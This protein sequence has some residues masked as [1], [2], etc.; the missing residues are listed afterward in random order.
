MKILNQFSLY[1]N[2]LIAK[3]KLTNEKRQEYID[4]SQQGNSL[5]VFPKF[6]RADKEIVTRSMIKDC[7]I[8]QLQFVHKALQ[9]DKDIAKQAIISNPNNI[10]Y[11]YRSLKDDENFLLDLA[12]DENAIIHLPA[13][14]SR[15]IKDESFILEYLKIKANHVLPSL[16]LCK[17]LTSNINFMREAV[18]HSPYVY[19]YVNK[20]NIQDKTLATIVFSNLNFHIYNPKLINLY[21]SFYA[22]KYEFNLLI[23]RNN[24]NIFKFLSNDLQENP[25][26]CK[27]V[28]N[29][30][31]LGQESIY[32]EEFKK[33]KNIIFEILSQKPNVYKDLHPEM[34]LE[35]R[36]AKAAL[37]LDAKNFAYLPDKLSKNTA[38]LKIIY[39]E[40]PNFLNHL[41][42]NPYHEYL[43]S[44]K[45][46]VLL[47]ISQLKNTPELF[48]KINKIHSNDLEIISKSL[49]ENPACYEY[50][51]N[52]QREQ[53]NYIIA[54]LSQKIFK[55]IRYIP[56]SIFKNT[57]NIDKLLYNMQQKD[58]FKPTE[59]EKDK[60]HL[61]RLAYKIF[62]NNNDYQNIFERLGYSN[63]IEL[64]NQS[65]FD[66]FSFFNEILK[67]KQA[68]DT[69]KCLIN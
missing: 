15:L 63:F 48:Q 66:I 33:N 7:P 45:K 47:S 22:D 68:L 51:S 17:E 37:I 56:D 13:L 2:E 28:V 3:N 11:V 14:S 19:Q 8:E 35:A 10:K 50:L 39:K 61:I 55:N 6:V 34:K 40:N 25:E 12:K 30:H 64:Q 69:E 26:I 36:I 52:K 62:L 29:T 4:K 60:F 1:F 54:S 57:N 46:F 31:N 18:K 59:N 20:K 49:Y 42:E 41:M 16:T 32:K 9:S 43:L 21:K 58:F 67:H 65:N 24:I 44:D 5:A 53:E 27:L 23:L 38:F